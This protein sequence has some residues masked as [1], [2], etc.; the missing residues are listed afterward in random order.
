MIEESGPLSASYQI[1]QCDQDSQK[2]HLL[3][4]T[5]Q[6][7]SWDHGALPCLSLHCLGCVFVA[8]SVF[9]LL[10]TVSHITCKCTFSLLVIFCRDD[11][12]YY[13]FCLYWDMEYHLLTC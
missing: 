1:H 4:V 9:L 10:V 13:M 2:N 11:T 5:F 8:V 6:S 12:L 3:G 7:W